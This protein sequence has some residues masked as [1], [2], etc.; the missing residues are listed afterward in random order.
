MTTIR[1]CSAARTLRLVGACLL[2]CSLS[3]SLGSAKPDFGVRGG[4]YS[5]EGEPFLGAETL[6]DVGATKRWFGNPNLEH[7][8]VDDGDL[9]TISLDFHYDFLTGEPY[10]IWA[11]AGPTIIFTDR[12]ASGNDDDTEAG[13]N[14]V[15]GVGAQKGDVRP[16]GQ[17]KL[18][19]ADDPQAVLAGGIRF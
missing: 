16:Y 4:A 13:L 9:T 12:D 18:I 8:F 5:D 6:F 7:A 10:T 19:V 15:F 1:E 2:S 3:V 17:M 14:L 11:G